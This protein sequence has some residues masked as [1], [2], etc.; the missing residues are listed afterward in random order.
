[1][2]KIVTLMFVLFI[3]FAV[4]AGS[5]GAPGK[6]WA[7]TL[8]SGYL[9]VGT[10]KLHLPMLVRNS[11]GNVAASINQP[12]DCGLMPVV[13]NL[14]TGD[15]SVVGEVNMHHDSQFLYVDITAAGGQCLT[16]IQLQVAT[17][18][19]GIPQVDGIPQPDQFEYK[20]TFNE[21]TQSYT[22]ALPMRSEWTKANSLVIAVH[23]DTTEQQTGAQ[24]SAWGDCTPF[25]GDTAARYCT[26]QKAQTKVIPYN[27][28][29]GYEDLDLSSRFTDFDYNDWVTDIAGDLRY[30]RTAA[31]GTGFCGSLT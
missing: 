20:V 5:V 15:G 4:I 11:V 13:K 22:F 29:V 24:M 8:N 27:V 19:A 12:A 26:Y 1:M 23:V 14:V 2:K 7:S 9:Q 21:C 3:A 10:M 16:G 30:C 18:L 6:A 25:P 28:S 17:D 31:Q